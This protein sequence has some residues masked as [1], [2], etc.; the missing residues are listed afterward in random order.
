MRWSG[1]QVLSGQVVRA[2][3]VSMMAI[4]QSGPGGPDGSCGTYGPDDQGGQPG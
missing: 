2:N 4:G 3:K 1:V